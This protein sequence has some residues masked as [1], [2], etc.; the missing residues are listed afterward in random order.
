[1]PN[2]VHSCDNYLAYNIRRVFVMSYE[3]RRYS[4]GKKFYIY[5][6]PIKGR[7][8][9]E[10]VLLSKRR[11]PNPPFR[12]AATWQCSVYYFWWEY[13]RRHEGY[14]LC[15]FQNGSGKYEK[16]Y[17]DFGDIHASDDFWVWWREH[18]HLFAEPPARQLRKL[19]G[20]ET[21]T[22]EKDTL[23]IEV[24]LEV[25]MPYLVKALR[26]LLKE[27]GAEVRRVKSI[28]RAHYPVYTKPNLGSLYQTLLFWD[29]YS[30]NP[31]LKLH[32]L[33]DVCAARLAAVG[34]GIWVD[35]TVDG[36]TVEH[37]KGLDLPY[38]DVLRVIRR[39]KT[40]AAKRH[41][42]IAEQYIENAALGE[43]PKKTRR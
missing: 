20:F 35:E 37:L 39:R 14:K 40:N 32:E 10:G 27:N 9:R 19:N 21:H 23:R 3:S 1:M 2:G 12:N 33:F 16:L 25:R 43:F 28:S 7:K 30:A 6:P 17:K 29:E 4:V 31:Q 15:C 22:F 34:N 8:N 24:P 36:E 26:K 18:D 5:A 41:L 13:L 38:G 11:L 42:T